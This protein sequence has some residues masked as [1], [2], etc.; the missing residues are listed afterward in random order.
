MRGMKL[1]LIEDDPALARGIALG[2]AAEGTEIKLAGTLREAEDLLRQSA[3]SLILLDLYL[4]DGN[5]LDFLSRLRREC[6]TPVL[7]LTA[8]DLES[9]QVA[10]FE[11]GADDYVTKPFSLAVLRA[12]VRSLLRRG[13]PK[14][15]A[16]EIPPFLFDFERMRFSRAGEPLELS[17]TEQRLLRLL[18]ENQGRT[19][20]RELLLQRVWDGGEFVDEN[21]LSVAIRR[22]R[23]KL[24][25]PPIKTVYGIGYLWEERTP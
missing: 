4:P 24:V 12:R 5:G 8:N 13:E 21:T 10:G 9:D 19:L 7:I 25:D 23:G 16:W 2:L 22:L 15:R 17:K 14:G 11:L 1:L 18:I 3:F 6:R 20:P